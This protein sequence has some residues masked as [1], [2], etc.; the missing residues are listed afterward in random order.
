MC[1][2]LNCSH[3]NPLNCIVPPY[4]LRVLELRGDEPWRIWRASY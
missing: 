3:H 1:F 4:M 2:S